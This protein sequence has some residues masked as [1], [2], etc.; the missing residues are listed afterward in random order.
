MCAEIDVLIRLDQ[1]SNQP[2]ESLLFWS[3]AAVE[4]GTDLKML[5]LTTGPSVDPGT[6]WVNR[7]WSMRVSLLDRPARPTLALIA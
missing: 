3:L 2:D 7:A 5:D 4:E 1:S 6:N